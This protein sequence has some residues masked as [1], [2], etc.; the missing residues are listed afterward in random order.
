MR[1]S[2]ILTSL[3]VVH[4][5]STTIYIYIKKKKIRRQGPPSPHH[6]HS[7][8][9]VYMYMY[10]LY[11][12]IYTYTNVH[13]DRT[14]DDIY[15][16]WSRGFHHQWLLEWFKETHPPYKSNNRLLNYFLRVPFKIS[17]F[18]SDDKTYVGVF[19]LIRYSQKRKKNKKKKKRQRNK[20]KKKKG[21][22]LSSTT[23]RTHVLLLNVMHIT[24][25]V[26]FFF[27]SYFF[28]FFQNL[29]HVPFFLFIFFSSSSLL[30]HDNLASSISS[31]LI[32]LVPTH[33]CRF[34][35]STNLLCAIIKIH[36][37]D[38]SIFISFFVFC[39]FN[40]NVDEIIKKKKEPKRKKNKEIRTRNQSLLKCIYIYAHVIPLVIIF[41]GQL[42]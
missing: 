41:F 37:R 19:F 6:I 42:T 4:G 34:A 11:I 31:T 9:R 15:V 5:V 8:T 25:S 18:L 36:R 28:F 26:Y 23:V 14:S 35:P 12:Y 33:A 27:F 29:F 3:T 22:F 16:P 17:T 38:C 2:E 39:F 10:I 32:A 21:T 13:T 1:L 40:V 24:V 20:Q 30:L 7:H